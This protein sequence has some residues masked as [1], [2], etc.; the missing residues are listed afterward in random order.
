MSIQILQNLR[1]AITH[2]ETK[3]SSEWNFS[4]HYRTEYKGEIITRIHLQQHSL[5]DQS[6]ENGPILPPPDTIQHSFNFQKLWQSI[7][8]TKVNRNMF[9]F[10]KNGTLDRWNAKRENPISF[11]F[12][13]PFLCEQALCVY[14]EQPFSP[15]K[16]FYQHGTPALFPATWILLVKVIHQTPCDTKDLIYTCRKIFIL[17]Y[18]KAEYLWPPNYNANNMQ[19]RKRKRK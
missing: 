14:Q 17:H 6:T 3:N 16:A 10:S 5:Y 11:R 9:K 8:S 4:W 13:I 12:S 18:K 15:R 1:L 19:I 7:D 2:A